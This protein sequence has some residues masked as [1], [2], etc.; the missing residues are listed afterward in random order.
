[1]RAGVMAVAAALFAAGGAVA[2]AQE[3]GAAERAELTGRL[4]VLDAELQAIRGRL[5]G[6]QGASGGAAVQAEVLGRLAAFETELR[7]LTA[8]LEALEF[9]QRQARADAEAR[10]QFLD[11]RLSLLEESGPAGA[12]PP[13]QTPPP[14]TAAPQTAAPTAPPQNPPAASAPTLGAPPAALGTMRV[15]VP[16]PERAAFDAAAR[17]LELRGLRGGEKP[18]TDFLL[19]FPDSALAGEAWR[20]LGE[21]FAA[22]GRHQEAARAHLAGVRDHGALP[23][24]PE[25]LLGLATALAQ[26]GRL[27]E[28]CATFAEFSS[29]FPSAGPSLQARAREGAARASCG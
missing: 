4:Q 21:T 1:M 24:A 7:R 20:L 10:W 18:M 22:A 6:Q 16:G 13:P 3:L 17:E 29:R 26:L 25:N 9:A 28:A 27:S 19:D 8:N 12:S 15:T 14:Q 23:G 11:D 5:G 2:P